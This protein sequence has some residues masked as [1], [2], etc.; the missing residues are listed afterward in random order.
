MNAERGLTVLV[1]AAVVYYL[2]VLS[3]IVY[4]VVG[5]FEG[6]SFLI[7]VSPLFFIFLGL[8][9]IVAHR[10]YLAERPLARFAAFGFSVSP[11][12]FSILYLLRR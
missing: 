8:R 9:F 6:V 1:F 4:D 2:C 3:A 12:A 11:V 7:D 10:G 5:Y